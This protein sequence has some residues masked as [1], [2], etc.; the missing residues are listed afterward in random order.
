MVD[1]SKWDKLED[2]HAEEARSS[3]LFPVPPLSGSPLS[4]PV[5]PLKHDM[6]TAGMIQ[7]VYDA[8]CRTCLMSIEL[9]KRKSTLTCK[10]KV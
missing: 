5:L 8:S 1:Y 7:V 6:F 4:P 2:S 3:A 9:V 10:N